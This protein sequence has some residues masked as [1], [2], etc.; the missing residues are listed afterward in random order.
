MSSIRFAVAVMFV[1]SC[2]GCG[3]SYSNPSNP[4]PTPT[5][6]PTGTGTQVTIASGASTRTTTAYA[7][8]PVT[9]AVGGA[10]TWV[11]SDTIAHTST[12]DN[13]A[14]NS[15]SIAA[16]GM[17]TRTFSS[18]GTF[19]YHCTIHPGMVGTVTVQ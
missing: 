4:T 5:P 1:I 12:G 17:F 2:A 11:N 18:A 10:V 19:T 7:P 8:N 13:N 15:G 16:G 14:W 6:T 3:S 9:V